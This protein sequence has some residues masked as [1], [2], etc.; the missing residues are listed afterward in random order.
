L[1]DQPVS[2]HR[3]PL[4][5]RFARWRRNHKAQVAAI[6]SAVAVL[7]IGGVIGL[8]ISRRINEHTQ[9]IARAEGLVDALVRADAQQLPELLKQLGQHPTLAMPLVA[10]KLTQAKEDSTEKL[11]LSLAMVGSD[12]GQ[13]EYLCEQ[14]L[15][16]HVS[17][18]GVIRDRLAPFERCVEAELWELLHSDSSVG[19]TKDPARRFRAGLALATYATFSEQWTPDDQTFLVAQFVAANPEHQPRIREYLRPLDSRLLGDLERVFADAKAT[20]SQQLSAANALADFSAKD[21]VR[22]RA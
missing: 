10:E 3:E 4:R 20:E 1:N 8:T 13:V 16:R 22:L 12:E 14:L 2:I 7:V 9:N 17:Y 19:G 11:H 15:S 6:S 5:Q 18:L 21:P